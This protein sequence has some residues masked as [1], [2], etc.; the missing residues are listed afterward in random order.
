MDGGL[1]DVS[2]FAGNE[3]A[4]SGAW[5]NRIRSGWERERLS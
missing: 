5:R 4:K 2:F 3:G 1:F